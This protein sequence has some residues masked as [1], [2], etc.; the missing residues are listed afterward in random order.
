MPLSNQLLGHLLITYY[1]VEISWQIGSQLA[2]DVCLELIKKAFLACQNVPARF[3]FPRVG[4]SAFKAV[5]LH[6]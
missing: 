2:M 6:M 3:C 4:E 1:L 5:R